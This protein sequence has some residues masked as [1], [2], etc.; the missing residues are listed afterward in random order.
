MARAFCG[1]RQPASKKKAKG[2]VLPTSLV[3]QQRARNLWSIH[4]QSPALHSIQSEARASPNRP[5]PSTTISNYP[6]GFFARDFFA[7]FLQAL[8]ISP[9]LGPL[10]DFSICHTAIF[11]PTCPS[12]RIHPPLQLASNHW[13]HRKLHQGRPEQ[14]PLH[15][16]TLGPCLRRRATALL[17]I[18]TSTSPVFGHPSSG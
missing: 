15:P 2:A 1:L 10:F 18:P 16:L 8:A 13:S 7:P 3:S 17:C 6:A 4:S 5:Q 12:L 9:P 14:R 11:T